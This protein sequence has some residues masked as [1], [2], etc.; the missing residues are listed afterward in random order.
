MIQR[1]N[2]LWLAE[3][4]KTQAQEHNFNLSHVMTA[5]N[6][7][8]YV[9]DPWGPFKLMRASQWDHVEP[10]EGGYIIFP[11]GYKAPLESQWT[12]GC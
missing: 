4:W 1:E 6:L 8:P 12:M 2:I 9:R 3:E 11:E 5:M 10:E 7:S